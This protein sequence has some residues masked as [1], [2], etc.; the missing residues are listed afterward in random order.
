M[1]ASHA[2]FAYFSQI[3]SH[4]GS[5]THNKPLYHKTDGK[6]TARGFYAIYL[7]DEAWLRYV[8]FSFDAALAL[9]GAILFSLQIDTSTV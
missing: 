3:G 1:I 2:H 7:N 4:Q 9:I 5:S 8:K 6:T